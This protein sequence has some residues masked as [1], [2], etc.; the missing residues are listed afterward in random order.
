MIIAGID[1]GLKGGIAFIKNVSYDLYAEEAPVYELKTNTKTKRYLDMWTLMTLLE[2][3]EPD[4]VYIEKQ[5]P[6]PRQ[7]LVS[8]FATG[9]GYGC[10][11]GLLVAGG[12][13]YT[14]V[15]P[16]IWKKD[17]NCTA[18]KDQT[19]MRASE[20]MPKYSHLWEK[21]SQDGV[22]EASLIAYWG[23]RYSIERF[24]EA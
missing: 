5:Q 16:Q 2:E 9:V 17:L 4:H 23:M 6:M 20:L 3:H 15:R 11:L 19:R 8:T 13:S 21:R 14:E 24:R 22:A 12:Y 10:Y 7:G 1:P 18:D